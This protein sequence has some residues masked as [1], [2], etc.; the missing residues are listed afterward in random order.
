MET[1]G[2][3]WLVRSNVK[4]SLRINKQINLG[5]HPIRTINTFHESQEEPHLT[6]SGTAK[7]I[8]SQKLN[9]SPQILHDEVTDEPSRIMKEIYSLQEESKEEFAKT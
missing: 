2:S 7:K 9:Q 5:H 8:N 6:P 1:S 3:G 4:E